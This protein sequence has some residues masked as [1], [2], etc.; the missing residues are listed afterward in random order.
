MYFND[1][2]TKNTVPKHK[3]EWYDVGG[4]N[5]GPVYQMCVAAEGCPAER[6]N[7]ERT[8]PKRVNGSTSLYATR[9]YAKGKGDNG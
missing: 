2:R 1:R 6:H 5:H 8:T 3:H 9:T 4:D 7:E